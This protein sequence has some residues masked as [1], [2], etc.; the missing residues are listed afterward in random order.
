MAKFFDK[1][2]DKF[3]AVCVVVALLYSFWVLYDTTLVYA[4]AKSETKTDTAL[5]DYIS[6]NP[7]V[8][9]I[10]SIPGTGVHYPV[11]QGKDNIEYL[12]KNVYGKDSLS[13]SIYID[14]GNS[15]DFSDGYTLL[16]GHRMEAGA[17]FG[18]IGRFTEAD[19]FREHPTGTLETPEG[20]YTIQFFSVMRAN[21]SD[22][23]I[24]D[25][26][27]ANK[28][29]TALERH[30]AENDLWAIEKPEGRMIALSTCENATTTGRIVL[31]GV[32]N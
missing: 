1:V 31:F 23:F 13:G 20:T 5:A 4:E 25:V 24:F 11:V 6:Q 15:K 10:L 17:M 32:I 7:D 19:F 27:T 14:A 8:A 22:K 18:D 29:V 3:I 9:A 21:A 30:I 2:L 28:D 12:N 26:D 16:Y